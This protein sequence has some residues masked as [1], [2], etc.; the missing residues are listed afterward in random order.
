[1]PFPFGFN[2][3]NE[4]GQSRDYAINP[5]FIPPEW[6]QQMESQ[7]G[8]NYNLQNFL[9][10]QIGGM[11]GNYLGGKN[12][13]IAGGALAG[14]LS[15]SPW[16]Q[17]GGQLGSTGGGMLGNYLGSQIGMGKAGRDLGSSWGKSI[18]SILGGA[19]GGGFQGYMMPTIGGGLSS[20]MGKIGSYT[21]LGQGNGEGSAPPNTPSTPRYARGGQVE[22]LRGIAEFL[23]NMG[24]GSD[25]VLAHINPE[26]AM[27]LE[28]KYGG[29]INPH[30]G[31][32]QYGWFSDIWESVAPILGTT[33]GSIFGGP[34]GGIL[35][36]ALGGVGSKAGGNRH[37]M[38]K[39]ALSGGLGGALSGYG[40]QILSSL[41]GKSGAG[42]GGIAGGLSSLFGGGNQTASEVSGRAI[43]GMGGQLSQ[44]AVSGNGGFLN[45]LLGSVASNPIDT[46]LGLTQL[47]GILGRKEKMPHTPTLSEE[48]DEY[49]KLR[50]KRG[51]NRSLEDLEKQ[52]A[53]EYIEEEE[54]RPFGRTRN[55]FT[56][57][58]AHGGYHLDGE[59]DGQEDKINAQLS[60]GEYVV[61]AAAVSALGNGNNKA[62][63]KKLD[64][65]MSNIMQHTH[66]NKYQPKSKSIQNYIR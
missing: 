30:T 9:T 64:K 54:E 56:N 46:V 42:G 43:P 31:L 10:P 45:N 55:Y 12:G 29:D 1:M 28:G 27:E 53:R 60:D 36:G 21:G 37:D 25:K 5:K 22:D 59:T 39:G 65:F 51:L 32:P 19:A 63:A 3:N 48:Y 20:L 35:G 44:K 62:G 14:A 16:S 41:M 47:A 2:Q 15:N 61:H 26:E 23:R 24:Q 66:K 13:A 17:M 8:S 52:P 49:E 38:F 6:T 4:G 7:Q 34:L 50:E 33:L 58:Y 57:N 11:I 40:P 18:G